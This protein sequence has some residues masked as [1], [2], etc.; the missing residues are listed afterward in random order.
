[1]GLAYFGMIATGGCVAG[2]S[3]PPPTFAALPAVTETMC[4]TS[5][6]ATAVYAFSAAVTA[7]PAFSPNMGATLPAGTPAYECSSHYAP[8]EAPLLGT[9]PVQV[10]QHVPV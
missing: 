3:S 10:G 4:V 8:L 2:P 5:P 9:L 1:M 6:R 7:T